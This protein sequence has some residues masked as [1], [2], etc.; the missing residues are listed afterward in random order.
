[1]NGFPSPPRS[2]SCPKI[3]KYEGGIYRERLKG[4]TLKEWE[5]SRDKEKDY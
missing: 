2:L 4:D 1:M 3:V 5:S